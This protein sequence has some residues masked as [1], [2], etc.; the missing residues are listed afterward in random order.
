MVVLVAQGTPIR[1]GAIFGDR[2]LAGGLIPVIAPRPDGLFHG[3]ALRPGWYKRIRRWVALAAASQSQSSRE[4]KGRAARDSQRRNCY[5]NASSSQFAG[6]PISPYHLSRR[7]IPLASS[8]GRIDGFRT[9]VIGRQIAVLKL[10]DWR[11]SMAP[12]H[13][14]GF[15][16]PANP[17]LRRVR[18]PC[19]HTA[20]RS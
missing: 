4:S 5:P 14:I 6:W 10:V 11:S 7:P 12:K 15:P 3:P 17:W 16:I 13:P 20:P 19:A 1:R 2:S 8:V 9:R 18:S